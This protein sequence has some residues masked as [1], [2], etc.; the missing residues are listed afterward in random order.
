MT[1]NKTKNKINIVIHFIIIIPKIQE[2]NREQGREE[3][4]PE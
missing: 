3:Q 4:E 1:M 2:P